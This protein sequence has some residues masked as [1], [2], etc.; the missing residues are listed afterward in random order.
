MMTLKEV[1]RL[2][3]A[4]WFPRYKTIYAVRESVLRYDFEGFYYVD[5]WANIVIVDEE[6]VNLFLKREIKLKALGNF[7]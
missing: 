1:K 4:K 3:P 5:E 6:C 2:Y 7:K